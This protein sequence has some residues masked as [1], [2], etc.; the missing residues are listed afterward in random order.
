MTS[1]VTHNPREGEQVLESDSNHR[2]EGPREL[3]ARYEQAMIDLD[4]DALAELY[5]SDAVHEFGFIVPGHEPSYHGRDAIRAAYRAAWGAPSVRLV[6]MHHRALHETTNP[7]MLVAEWAGTARSTAGKTVDLAG[8]LVVRAR[9]GYLVHVRDY[10]DVF[11]LAYQ[12]GRLQDLAR[13]ADRA[14]SSVQPGLPA[15]RRPH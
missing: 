9:D 1:A 12:S 10:M 4:A 6:E 3:L 5:A 2:I 8:V 14:S 15:P 13:S 7:E 11:G